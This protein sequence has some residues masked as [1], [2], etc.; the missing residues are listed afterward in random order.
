MYKVKGFNKLT[1]YAEA[2]GVSVP[3]NDC[4]I[5]SIKFDSRIAAKGDLFI[6]L[7]GSKF[8]GEDFV[9][10]ALKQGAASITKQ[11]LFCLVL[12]NDDVYECLLTLAKNNLQNIRPKIIFITGSYGKTTIKDMLKHF[13]GN[14]V[15]A[16][17]KTKIMN[18]GFHTL[19]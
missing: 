6:P 3:E 11:N 16:A 1:D 8:N 15:I 17:K 19:F 7:E 9:K 14:N 5:N 10:T 13:L 12:H 4:E 2:L 18:L